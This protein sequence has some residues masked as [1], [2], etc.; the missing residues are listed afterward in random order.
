[1]DFPEEDESEA[2]LWK[3]W[4]LPPC[5]VTWRSL[6]PGGIFGGRGADEEERH[7]SGRVLPLSAQVLYNPE[8]VKCYLKIPAVTRTYLILTRWKKNT[9]LIEIVLREDP[10]VVGF[11]AQ[12]L[13]G[14]RQSQKNAQTSNAI[15][16][17]T[18]LL[19]DV[20]QRG[21]SSSQRRPV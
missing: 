9:Q 14:S 11:Q 4:T 3:T 13:F 16:H 18:Q 2:A 6:V 19:L 1:M 12:L 10:V 21:G 17:Q 8:E 15:L 5:L 7:L 20:C